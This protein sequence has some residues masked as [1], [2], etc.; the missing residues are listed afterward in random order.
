[1]GRLCAWSKRCRVVGQTS[2]DRREAWLVIRSLAFR[3]PS[4]IAWLLILGGD[5]GYISS[6]LEY[7]G[8]RLS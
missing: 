1:M 3:L 5:C 8:L 6:H 7:C 2:S 4:L